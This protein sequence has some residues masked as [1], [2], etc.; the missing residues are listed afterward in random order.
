MQLSS[1]IYNIS[2]YPPQ[3]DDNNNGVIQSDDV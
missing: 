1:Q 2:F 3:P